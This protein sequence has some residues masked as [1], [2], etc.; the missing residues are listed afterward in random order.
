VNLGGRLVSW[1][2]F[3]GTLSEL[4]GRR[5]PL[6]FPT[7]R[8]MA[9]ATGRLADFVSRVLRRR[10]PIGYEN[11]WILYQMDD[12]DDGQAEELVGAPP[13]FAETMAEAVRW[14]AQAGQVRPRLAGRL[15][16]AALPA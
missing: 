14:M 12:T 13:P 3:M 5:L 16:T 2:E 4:T 8:R 1:S 15:R 10:L 9:L 7:T 11:S 6:I